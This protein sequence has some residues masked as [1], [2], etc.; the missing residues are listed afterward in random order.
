MDETLD[1]LPLLDVVIYPGTVTPLAVS[2]PDALRLLGDGSGPHRLAVVALRDPLR[3]PEPV[4]PGDCFAVG[5]AA[6]VH[7]LLRLP[8]GSLRVAVEGVGRVAL[9][10][11]APSAAGGLRARCR[12]LP[13]RPS[14]DADL[15]ALIAA[16]RGHL[17]ACAARP[18]GVSPDLLADIAAEDDPARLSFLLAGPLLDRAP[19]AVRQ[20][21]LELAAPADRLALLADRLGAPPAAP[22]ALPEAAPAPRR[23]PGRA[24]WLRLTAAG[25]ALATAEAAALPDPSELIIT[26]QTG[27]AARDAALVARTW[28]IGYA[29]R[30]GL[31]P[32][33]GLHLHAPPGAAR[34]DYAAASA[35]LALAGLSLLRGRGPRPDIA[36]V[37]EL[38]LHGHLLPVGRLRERIAAARALGLAALA[39]AAGHAEELAALPPELRAGLELHLVERLDDAVDL[40]L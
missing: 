25:F 15:D 4:G 31:G 13:D 18:P 8:D 14:P 22:P 24:P 3:R 32:V 29:G 40:L 33:G 5:C 7:R 19:L 23:D 39:L 30:A 26:G 17:A 10:A 9:D 2:H 34:A 16:L 27:R 6:L 37:G 21:L 11:A 1:I 35:P 12:P 28:L 38:G 20:R 36:L